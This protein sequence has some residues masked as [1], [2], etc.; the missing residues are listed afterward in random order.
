[1]YRPEI[2]NVFFCKSWIVNTLGFVCQTMSV[3]NIQLCCC[4]AKRTVSSRYTDI[5]VKLF[6]NIGEG[7]ELAGRPYFAE[8]DRGDLG[9]SV[10]FTPIPLL[11]A[12]PHPHAGG[13][14]A[15]P[16]TEP[17]S[18]DCSRQL[19]TPLRTPSQW[20][21]V[22]S[23]IVIPSLPLSLYPMLSVSLKIDKLRKKRRKFSLL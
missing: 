21:A 7:S 17:G 6:T 11:A 18:K 23:L 16:S 12:P 15:L 14:P 5:P 2:S 1:M 3:T 9:V 19:P 8:L 20:L 22:Q 4:S 10:C 13:I